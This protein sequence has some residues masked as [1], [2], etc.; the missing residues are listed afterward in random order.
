MVADKKSNQ[1]H[2]AS[3]YYYILV[4]GLAAEAYVTGASHVIG[5]LR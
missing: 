5:I 1:P 2:M 4:H 3:I